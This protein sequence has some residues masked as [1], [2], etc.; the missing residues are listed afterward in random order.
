MF[1]ILDDPRIT[2]IGASL[3]K[4]S[5][6]EC[7][8]SCDVLRGEMS[9][10]GPRPLDPRRGSAHRRLER[11]RAR[12]D[13]G[14]TVSGRSS[15]AATFPLPRSSPSTTSTSRTGRCSAT[16]SCSRR[17]S[18]PCCNDAGPTRAAGAGMVAEVAVESDELGA[19]DLRVAV[20]ASA[21]S[22]ASPQRASP[23]GATPSSASTS[24]PE[25]VALL[26]AAKPTDG[27]GADRRARRRGGRVRP[28]AAP[29]PTLP[30]AIAATDVAL[31][32]VGTP[33]RPNGA[34][35]HELLERVV[36][37]R[38]ARR[39]ATQERRYTRRHPQHDASRHVRGRAGPAAGGGLRASV[40][41][42]TSASR[43]NPEFL[44]EGSSRQGLLRP[45]KT[46]IGEL[47]EASG[48]VVAALYD[49]APGAGRPGADP[50]RGDD[51]VRRQQ[52]PRAEGRLR[53][54]DRR[55]LQARSASTRTR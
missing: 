32:C 24:N 9:L 31:V 25:K 4:W 36:P 10:V 48:D 2:P 35:D 7:R 52:L 13:A 49:G 30:Q 39:C 6:D 45:P 44:R 11:R 28:A 20:S 19:R 38:S 17:R 55:D 46:V 14:I 50:R 27:R 16:S 47:D 53:E 29:R 43:V 15:A 23:T 42:V 8:S 21:T 34:L 18:P 51:E 26:A 54:R 5:I 1:K 22:G 3:R 37:T 12:P 33:S 41:G 40:A